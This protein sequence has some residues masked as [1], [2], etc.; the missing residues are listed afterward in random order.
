M[1]ETAGKDGWEKINPGRRNR[2][3]KKETALSYLI[4]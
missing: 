2:R 3:R 4:I 1:P